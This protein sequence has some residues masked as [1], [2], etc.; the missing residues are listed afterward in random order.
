V[1]GATEWHINSDEPDVLDYDTTFKPDAQDALYEPNAYRSSDHDPV[2]DVRRE[3]AIYWKDAFGV[4]QEVFVTL[5]TVDLAGGEQDLLLKVQG[6]YGPNWGE[7]VIEAFYDP[8]SNTV[9]VWTFRLDTLKWHSYAPIPVTF[10][11]GDQFGA[12]ALSTGEVVIYKNG[13]EVGYVT[14]NAADQTFFNSKGGHIGL[15]FLD[16]RDAFFDD[17][18]GGDVTSP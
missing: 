15:W 11:D 17:F 18:G 13:V 7:G 4:N 9:T 2:V 3:G 10:A 6:Q 12:R 16:A 5:S 8:F 14:L 1:T